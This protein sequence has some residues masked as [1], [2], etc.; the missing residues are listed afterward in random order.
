MPISA[1]AKI[2]FIKYAKAANK[3]DIQKLREQVVYN[4]FNS[5]TAFGLAKSKESNIKEWYDYIKEILEP[6]ITI[7]REND[8]KKI[9]T[10]L[11]KEKAQLHNNVEFN[12]FF[13][14]L[15]DSIEGV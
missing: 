13:G 1:E 14:R 9:I 7:L 8:Q 15:I 11:T 10:L 12:S 6:D 4:I 3:D 2:A 5:E